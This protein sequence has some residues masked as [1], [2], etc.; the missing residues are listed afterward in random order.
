M[1]QSYRYDARVSTMSTSTGDPT[2]SIV[3]EETTRC[4]RAKLHTYDQ[5]HLR[6]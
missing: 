1:L 2:N 3:S 5:M 6:R 4:T